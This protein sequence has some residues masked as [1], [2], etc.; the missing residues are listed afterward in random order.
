MLKNYLIVAFR[1][2][3]KQKAYAFINVFGLAIGLASAIL[4]F[5]YIIDE[6]SYDT[7]HQQSQ[8]T[9]RI[10]AT[11]TFDDGNQTNMAGVPGGWGPKLMELYP[12]V[13]KSMRYFW[14][15]YPASVAFQEADKVLLTE[16]IYWVEPSY[17][18]VLYF[19][20]VYGN[21][22]K[23][24]DLPKSIVITASA[25]R[26]FFEDENPVGKTLV[27]RHPFVTQNQDL[28]LMV[29]AVIADYPSNS[30]LKPE[31]LVNFNALRPF[32]QGQF[33]QY[34]SNMSQG[35][36]STY[37][38]TRADANI[39][40]LN[41]GLKSMSDEHM[42]Q[43]ADQVSPFLRNITD[44]HFDQE[45]NWVNQGG[46]N[47]LYVYI[48]GSI[49][50]LIIVIACINYMN[51]ATAKAAKRSREV[52]LRKS[53]GSNKIQLMFQFY[54]ES[55]LTSLL[56]LILALFLVIILL[57]YFNDLA[58]KSFTISALWNKWLIL[59]LLGILL[60]VTFVSGSYPAIYLSRFKPSDVLKG[61][62]SSGKGA[63]RFRKVLVVTQFVISMVFIIST[64]F[65]LRQMKFIQSSKL[66]E[67]GDQIV[68]IRYGGI[69]PANKYQ[70]FKNQTLQEA[71]VD[72]MT[73]GNHLPRL[74]Y[75][76]SINNTI[77]FPDVNNEEYQWSQLNVDFEFPQTFE[78]EIIAGRDFDQSNVADSSAYLLNQTAVQ[79]LGLSPE[80]AVGLEIL[81][82]QP[83]INGKIIGVV[84]DFPF[85][86]M[87]QAIGPLVISGRPH[88]V[89]RIV[90]VKLPAARVQTTL[91][92]LEK[93]WKQVF[94]GIGFDYWFLDQEFG[95]MYAS[96]AKMAD[97]TRSF[98]ILTILIASLGLFGLASY[99][100][101]QK[102][103]EVGVRKVL[104]ASI[105]QILFLLIISFLKILV[106]ACLFAVPLA[107]LLMNNWLQNFV[108]HVPLDGVVFLFSILGIFL[109]TI[110]TVAYEIIKVSAIN[111]V[112]ALRYE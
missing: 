61:Q 52:G 88:P 40:Q 12:E 95:R 68:S 66:N 9:Y 78:L 19:D 53:F 103:K 85:R 89:D 55:L 50:L 67:S 4:I 27:V 72:D 97:L 76:G 109:L 77:Q 108:Y 38:I 100:A 30:H 41:Q 81:E 74:D 54:N 2:L 49:A 96:E 62:F 23:A 45:V 63:E 8:N 5:L 99:T 104:G 7:I 91:S 110:I 22:E 94:P 10:G 35:F 28:N 34:F 33:D 73:L 43:L 75:F 84:E 57:P 42:G 37:I 51:L 80:E 87:H 47:I 56:S 106:I 24:F 93:S 18:E 14:A 1:N 64:I 29:S 70:T 79:A 15:G 111:P 83:G 112:N 69:A 36:V 46:G 44:L 13:E 60:F 65:I 20:V 17:P 71:A 58:Q 3:T 101:E 48:F 90:Y 25:A 39:E 6:L 11:R 31:Y 32:F 59:S 16:E 105:P 26:R 86:S 107:Y 102:T 98:S 82:V 21:A 92:A